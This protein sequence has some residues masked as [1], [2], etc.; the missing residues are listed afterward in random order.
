MTILE[1]LANHY[2][3][4]GIWPVNSP[5]FGCEHLAECRKSND[6]CDLLPIT[7]L[8]ATRSSPSSWQNTFTPGHSAY[9][10]VHYG[11]GVPR[12]LFVQLD[13][14]TVL[15]K[16]DPGYNLVSPESRT[17][18]GIRKMRELLLERVMNKEL[19]A[20]SPTVKGTN[21][22]ATAI[23]REFSGDVP[24]D[25]RVS[26]FYSRVNAV[27]CT[28]NKKGRGQAG[29]CLY[30]NCRERN[31]LRGEINI[32][33]PAVIVTFGGKARRGV[34]H[35]FREDA[36]GQES[37]PGVRIIAPN[38]GPQIFWLH[39]YHP[40]ARY[41]KGETMRPFE[42]QMAGLDDGPGLGGYAKL[43]HDFVADSEKN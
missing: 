33:K 12:L 27:K 28:V 42:I 20:P 35:A 26:R 1:E 7:P 9:A 3:E 22:V 41:R 30:D 18:E 11:D 36:I 34:E 13:L 40:T 6:G 31:Y 43:I 14:G 24:G 17:P 38:S 4:H 37:C 32:L 25:M 2:R 8:S 5:A 10:G 21:E 16:K 39:A 19:L 29:K 15:S 23:L